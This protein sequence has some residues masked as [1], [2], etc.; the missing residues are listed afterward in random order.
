MIIIRDT[1]I[2]NAQVKEHPAYQL[3]EIIDVVP[4]IKLDIRYATTNNFTGEIVYKSPKAFARQP[5][6]DALKIIQKE[7]NKQGLGIVVFD[8]Y[9]PYSA[10]VKFFEIYKDTN[11]VASPWSGSRHNRGAAVDVSIID[12][13]TGEEI[14]MPTAY[15]DF[16]EVAHPEYK[17]LPANVIKNRDMLINVMQNHGFRV[18][19]HEWW[20][21][22]FIGWEVYHLMDIPFDKLTLN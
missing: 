18:Y 4:D 21:F 15:D 10:T 20:H 5:V 17:N 12:L 16:T 19:P 13:K 1:S 9:R 3:V 2:Y 6:A 11:F 7:L 22:D 8:A 14:Q